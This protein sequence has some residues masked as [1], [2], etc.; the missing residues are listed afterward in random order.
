MNIPSFATGGVSSS[1]FNG[2]NYAADSDLRCQGA[3]NHRDPAAC[4]NPAIKSS[5]MLSAPPEDPMVGKMEFLSRPIIPSACRSVMSRCVGGAGTTTVCTVL[6]G[7][8]R[9]LAVPYQVRYRFL[10]MGAKFIALPWGG[11]PIVSAR[12]PV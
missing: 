5:T 12:F 3:Y 1:A 6:Y 10:S 4:R 7:K 8:G 11:P 2:V 9:S